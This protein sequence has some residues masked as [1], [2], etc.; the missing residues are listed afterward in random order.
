MKGL[1]S[2]ISILLSMGTVTV[3]SASCDQSALNT[4]SYLYDITEETTVF[5]VARK[6]NRGVCDIGRHNLMADVTI[7]PN[8][9][10]VFIIPGETCTPD[11][12]SC[13][14]KDV[15]RTRTCIYGGP[16]LYY[17]V[18]GDTYEKIA[19]RLNITTESLSGGQSANETLPVGQFIKVPECSPSQ[20]IIQPYSFE[21]GV[22]KDLADKYGTTVGQI[23][24]LSPTYNYSSL[25]F[26]S[27]GTA[28]P[29]DLPM[30]CTTLSNNITVIS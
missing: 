3:V 9:G 28:P 14:I 29:I 7:P 8:I 21:W 6:T 13:L 2:A 12:E 24:M 16:R 30:N 18:K 20:C 27:G 4:T 17:T 23:M 22:Y 15:G 1:I 19:L 26:S 11:N 10:E 25:A 5:E